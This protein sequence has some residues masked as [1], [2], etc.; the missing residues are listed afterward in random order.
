MLA[1][2]GAAAAAEDA[3]G[4]I[5]MERLRDAASLRRR[6]G[7]AGAAAAAALLA[8]PPPSEAGTESHGTKASAAVIDA[9]NAKFTALRLTTAALSGDGFFVVGE[10][11]RVGSK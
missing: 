9:I 1:S 10:D 8:M 7:A 4:A 5:A 6:G 3:L 11:R 2:E